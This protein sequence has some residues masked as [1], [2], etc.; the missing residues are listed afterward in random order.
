MRAMSAPRL[1][2]ALAALLASLAALGFAPADD[3]LVERADLGLRLRRPDASWV[4]HVAEGGTSPSTLGTV[5]LYQPA[6]PGVPNVTVFVARHDGQATSEQV[7]EAGA[8]LLERQGGTVL[9]RSDATLAGHP[10]ARLRGRLTGAD[11]RPYE[12]ELLYTVAPPLVYAAQSAWEGGEEFPEARLRPVLDS[13]E[14]VPRVEPPPPDADTLALQALAE[15][16]GSALPWAQSWDEAAARARAEDRVVLVVFE[17]YTG[18]EV[19]HT[20]AS[21]ALMDGDVEALLQERGVVLRLGQDDAAPFRSAQAWGMGPHSWGGAVLVVSPEGE[22][23]GQTALNNGFVVDALLRDAL[24][25]GAARRAHAALPRDRDE[26]LD[27]AETALRRGELGRAGELL[28]GA[29]TPRG[30]RLAASLA[31]RERHGE[32]ALAE[33]DSAAEGADAALLADLGVERGVVLMRLGRWADADAAL[34]SALERA[35]DGA[36]ATEAEFWLG[37]LEMLQQGFPAGRD[38]WRALAQAHPD[39]RWAWKAAANVLDGGAFVNGAERPHWPTEPV[40]AAVAHPPAAP[41]KTGAAGQAARDA[42]AF[43]LAGQQPDGSWVAPMDAFGVEPSGYT[44]ATTAIC[45]SSLLPHRAES[46]AVELSV[47]RAV[48]YLLAVHAAGGLQGGTSLM[49]VYSIWSRAFTL[50]FL[51]QARAAGLAGDGGADVAALDEA[52]PALLQSVL[53]SQQPSGGW[54]Y[55]LIAGTSAEQ[56]FDGSASFLTAGVLMALLEARGAGVEVPQAPLERGLAFLEGLRQSDGSFRYFAGVPQPTG[57]PE[58]AGRGPVCELALLRG[59]RGGLSTLRHALATFDGQREVLRREWGKDICHTGAQ[60]QGAHY[61]LYDWCFAARAAAE[62]PRSERKRWRRELL[63]DLLAVRDAEGAYADMP[64]LGRAY[65]TAM[66]LA[67][68]DAL[69]E[70]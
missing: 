50:R 31:R 14:L 2:V 60:G 46:D 67:A 15:R 20:R 70:S 66:A 53:D 62:L 8:K 22:V 17:Y 37:A 21:G 19:P 49:G 38:R 7:R 9:E 51:A 42:L 54:P 40:F 33:L 69:A 27:A 3:L 64:S 55:V 58:A 28:A 34:R 52:L 65:G 63:A 39:D 1:A 24:G 59:G 44:F 26:R 11:G 43:L 61:L 30:H 16:C 32:E 5:M 18:I 29:D 13:I 35:P 6:S 56:G 45:G 12:V 25:R 47:S 10:A 41:L 4:A 68:F 36:R 48:H 57:D 23:L